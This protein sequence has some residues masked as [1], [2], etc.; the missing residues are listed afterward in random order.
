MTFN[1]P[2][3]ADTHLFFFTLFHFPAFLATS[4]RNGNTMRVNLFRWVKFYVSSIF[5]FEVLFGCVWF[6]GNGL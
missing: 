5:F 2:R 6:G 3:F 4:A 1:P